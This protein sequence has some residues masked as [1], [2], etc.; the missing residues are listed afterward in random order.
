MDPLHFGLL[1][2]LVGLIC[3]VAGGVTWFMVG[4]IRAD[5]A[6]VQARAAVPTARKAATW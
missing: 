1:F 3:F 2:G 6:S 5:L 4:M